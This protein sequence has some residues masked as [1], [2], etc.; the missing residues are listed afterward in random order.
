[1]TVREYLNENL[2]PL[3]P[4]SWIVYDFDRT[5]TNISRITAIYVHKSVEPAPEHGSLMHTIS[6]IIADPT[7]SEEA[8]ETRLDDH[9]ADLLPLLQTIPGIDFQRASKGMRDGFP[10]WD[11]ELQIKTTS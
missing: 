4:G 7:Q 1:M 3:L 8:A 9:L 10:A 11:I 6:L 2:K 5:L